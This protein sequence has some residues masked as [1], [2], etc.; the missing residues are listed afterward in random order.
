[1]FKL[2]P[3]YSDTGPEILLHS[4]GT[5]D[6]WDSASWNTSVHPAWPLAGQQPRPQPCR[7]LHL[8]PCT[9]SC[10]REASERCGST[11]AA[12]DRGLVW[13]AADRC[14]WGNRRMEMT[15]PGVCPNKLA[16]VWTFIVTFYYDVANQPFQI[17]L[18][19]MFNDLKFRD[20][21][22]FVG[23]LPCSCLCCWCQRKTS[24]GTLFLIFIT[25]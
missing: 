18:V 3:L 22:C 7:L 21:H 12:P 9:A 2:L 20:W 14:G 5:C 10:V 8:G 4:S 16:A 24:A 17:L 13:P 1:M 25:K 6:G 19:V 11:E 15:S 23:V